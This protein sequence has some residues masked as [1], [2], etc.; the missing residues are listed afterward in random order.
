[1]K[2]KKL[3]SVLL[4]VLLLLS[5][6]QSIGLIAFAEETEP[7]IES[8]EIDDVEVYEGLDSVQAFFIT[9][10]EPDVTYEFQK[11]NYDLYGIINY[12]D[13]N[14][15][16]IEEGEYYSEYT[17]TYVTV[18]F[19]D[20]QSHTNE[21]KAGN[22]YDVTI[23]LGSV[24]DTFTVTV[25]ENPIK[26]IVVLDTTV[27]DGLDS[28]TAYEYDPITDKEGIP[29][30]CYEYNVD[31]AV[32]FND[33][34]ET[35]LWG[36]AFVYNDKVY[37]VNTDAIQNS[38]NQWA[39]GDVKTF[40]ASVGKITDEFTVTV[41]E[42]PV[43]SISIKDITVY[44]GLDSYDEYDYN[45]ETD[46]YDLEY[47][48]YSYSIDGTIEFKDGTTEEISNGMYYYNDNYY[49]LENNITQGYGNEWAVG[50]TYNYEAYI[51]DI[52][53]EFTVSVKKNPV[54][55]MDIDDITVYY[56]IDS[57]TEYDYN[58]ETD[59]YDLEYEHY[60]YLLTGTV[61]FE[62]GAEAPIKFSGFTYNG[63][64]YSV[65][66]NAEQGYNN[67]W[68]V[69][70]SY[71]CTAF[72]GDV[73]A[74]FTVKVEKNSV[75][76][77]EVEPVILFEGI[78]GV[79]SESFGYEGEQFFY[80]FSP[81][82]TVTLNNGTVLQSEYGKVK[83]DGK[84]Y[85]VDPLEIM[86]AQMEEAWGV[87][88]HKVELTLLGVKVTVDVFIMENPY[89]SLKI[90]GKNNLNITFTDKEGN[91]YSADAECFDAE[92]S[93]DIAEDGETVIASY[94]GMLYLDDGSSYYAKVSTA[95]AENGAPI[96]DKDVSLKIGSLTSNTLEEHKWVK[97][98]IKGLEYLTGYLLYGLYK[99]EYPE[100]NGK[101]TDENYE[102]LIMLSA[103]MYEETEVVDMDLDLEGGTI[104]IT[105]DSIKKAVEKV[106]GIKD[107]DITKFSGYNADS[108][109]TVTIPV[110]IEIMESVLS[111]KT[112]FAE[113]GWE[114]VLN[115][116]DEYPFDKLVIKTDEDFVI[117]SI[118]YAI[119]A[120]KDELKDI[121]SSGGVVDVVEKVEFE[122]KPSYDMDKG[123]D[124]IIPAT[125]DSAALV[126][127]VSIMI[128]SLAGLCFTSFFLRRKKN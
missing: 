11:Y 60:Y 37:D 1:M 8:I 63:N 6:V 45:T 117:K 25:K 30:K 89:E 4:A 93:I 20:G 53:D 61:Y 72:I 56:G 15:A 122:K 14:C 107:I 127:S 103:Y 43:K 98:Q 101:L 2:F 58:E 41:A 106:F 66:D 105:T 34:S 83:Y 85:E 39:V 113:D 46:D 118:K 90:S 69:G 38:A 102:D 48:Y 12:A 50:S 62:D 44:N 21:W 76:S 65:E 40:T 28:Y 82:Y 99:G 32:Y 24:S 68:K 5:S 84:Y 108:P 128:I 121:I 94:Q 125:G 88:E 26:K 52:K 27:I 115:G 124:G 77:I 87:G 57:M 29:Y 120:Q 71:K 78:N 80:I 109:E 104:S 70:K 13:G 23:T 92:I 110:S 91:E 42:S 16:Y 67:S 112:S 75:K 3:L 86:S 59:D 123:Y 74:D 51:G 35:E 54:V 36:G 31:G 116:I 126:L 22:S 100:Y 33:N 9:S 55:S 10:E 17:D 114:M 73:T 111:H 18:E 7:A 119:E 47:L 81:S 79:S 19:K 96:Y 95:S 49:V 64:T 97:A